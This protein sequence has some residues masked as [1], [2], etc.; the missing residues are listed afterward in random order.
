MNIEQKEMLLKLQ[1]GELDAVI[2][3]KKLAELSELEDIKDKLLEISADEGRHASIL[4][5]YTQEILK[6]SSEKA[7][8]IISLFKSVGKNKTFEVLA[9]GEFKGGPVYEKLGKCFDK[10]KEIAKDEI[11]HGNMLK[12]F[13]F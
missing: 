1:Q 10:L 13:I 6:P 9:E 3:Y 4:R 2:I 7:D 11:K 5:S 12:G 8:Q